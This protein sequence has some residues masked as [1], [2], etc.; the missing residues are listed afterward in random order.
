MPHTILELHC[1]TFV[2]SS[3]SMA[4]WFQA[5]TAVSLQSS[6]QQQGYELMETHDGT[7]AIVI[8]DFLI[9]NGFMDIP[10]S[11]VYTAG[12]HHALFSLSLTDVFHA[13]FGMSTDFAKVEGLPVSL[14]KSWELDTKAINFGQKHLRVSRTDTQALSE[15][16]KLGHP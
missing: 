8:V 6:L 14:G 7:G 12:P 10:A 9:N 1:W 4:H 11:S 16:W 13:D 15:G 3:G 5:L 2:V